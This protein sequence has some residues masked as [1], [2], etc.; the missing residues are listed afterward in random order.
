MKPPV[1]E[2]TGCHKRF[3][4]GGTSMRVVVTG[5]HMETG[6]VLRTHTETKMQELKAYFD[7]VMDVN[8]TF[9]HEPHHHNIHIADVVVHVSGLTLRAEGQGIDFYAALDESAHKL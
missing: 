7:Q 2:A 6:D 3:N 9:V 1:K 8:V 5:V 4:K